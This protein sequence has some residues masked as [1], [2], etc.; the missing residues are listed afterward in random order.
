[1][2][3]CFNYLKGGFH[4]FLLDLKTCILN[5][6]HWIVKNITCAE[7][8]LKAKVGK[9]TRFSV[10]KLNIEILPFRLD[11]YLEKTVFHMDIYSSNVIYKIPGDM[12]ICTVWW[13]VNAMNFLKTMLA[14]D[15]RLPEQQAE[16]RKLQLVNWPFDTVTG[17]IQPITMKFLPPS[18][19]S[20]PQTELQSKNEAH[21]RKRLPGMAT[22]R[23]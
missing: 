11:S 12:D 1:M 2:F 7:W 8:N 22:A 5:V 17:W 20:C 18:K 15:H 13:V 19:M 9:L 6:I 3:L 14:A 4:Y 16:N 21:T 10:R 23:Q